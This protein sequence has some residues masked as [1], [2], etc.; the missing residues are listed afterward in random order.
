MH[1]CINL[2]LSCWA[3]TTVA[4]LEFLFKKTYGKT[5]NLSEQYVVDCA[6]TAGKLIY[7]RLQG[8]NFGTEKISFFPVLACGMY[9]YLV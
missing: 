9:Y 3:F 2:I 5:A 8:K 7:F 1:S 6:S 4:A